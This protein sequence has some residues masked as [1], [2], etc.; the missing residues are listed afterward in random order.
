LCGIPTHYV[1]GGEDDDDNEMLVRRC[2]MIPLEVV[3]RGV[4]AGSFVKR[5]PRSRGHDSRAAAHRVLL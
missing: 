2:T 3:V 5:I 4:A 1:N